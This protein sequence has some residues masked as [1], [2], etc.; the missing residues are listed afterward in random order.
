LQAASPGGPE[1]QV[2]LL[3]LQHPVIS[4]MGTTKMCNTYQFWGG[5]W[6]YDEKMAKTVVAMKIKTLSVIHLH[7]RVWSSLR[8][9]NLTEPQTDYLAFVLFNILPTTRMCT[10]A[11]IFKIDLWRMLADCNRDLLIEHPRRLTGLAHDLKNVCAVAVDLGYP[12]AWVAP[13]DVP[14]LE[15]V[16]SGGSLLER[17]LEDGRKLIESRREADT[18][19][20][21][22]DSSESSS[23]R[24][25]GGIHIEIL[26]KEP[27]R[28]RAAAPSEGVERP[29]VYHKSPLIEEVE[30]PSDDDVEA[31]APAP[32][33]PAKDGE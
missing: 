5:R 20:T 28:I 6:N 27:L 26:K 30:Q 7:P 22:K 14:L 4:K 24:G 2:H 18:S 16:P 12:K 21:A 15:G 3:R 19:S 31:A 33:A 13:E 23:R 8:I 1:E 9:A 25:P 29:S 32:A 11:V 10:L 17:A